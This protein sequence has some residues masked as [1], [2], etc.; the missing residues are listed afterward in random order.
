M[1]GSNPFRRSKQITPGFQVDTGLPGLRD[2]T[3]TKDS[4]IGQAEHRF[5]SLDIGKQSFSYRSL[6]YV[7]SL[8]LTLPQNLRGSRRSPRARLYESSH[9]IR[10]HRARMEAAAA[11][12]MDSTHRPADQ[13]CSAPLHQRRLRPYLGRLM[14]VRKSIRSPQHQ[15][16]KTRQRMKTGLQVKMKWNILNLSKRRIP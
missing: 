10:Q 15:M 16:V 12:K 9:R 1:S 5:P 3:A 2:V 8:G 7:R 13:S 6:Q 11:I 4:E 14:V